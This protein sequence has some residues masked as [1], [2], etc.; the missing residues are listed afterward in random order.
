MK[1]QSR[2]RRKKQEKETKIYNRR[3]PNVRSGRKFEKKGAEENI[4]IGKKEET[5]W[6]KTN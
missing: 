3:K 1:M 4:D 6:G 5:N 2:E